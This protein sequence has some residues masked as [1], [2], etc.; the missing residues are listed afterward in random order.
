MI[1][2]DVVDLKLAQQRPKRDLHRFLNKIF[3]N[4]EKVLIFQ[5]ENQELLIWLFWS[6]KE[7]AYKAHQRQFN[8]ER[9]YNPLFFECSLS[10]LGENEAKGSVL[11]GNNKYATRSF[12]D[13]EKVYSIANFSKIENFIYEMLQDSSEAMKS[14]FLQQVSEAENI[15]KQSLSIAYNEHRVPQ[16]CHEAKNILIPF[17]FSHHGRFSGFA[18]ALNNY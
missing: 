9:R 18:F 12:F 14:K 5:N 2:N 11:A 8:L 3:S 15:P 16:L 13:F 7:A 17:S 6:M 10:F 4:N 1:G